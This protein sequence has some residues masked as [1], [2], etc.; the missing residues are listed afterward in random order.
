MYI[1]I[2]GICSGAMFLLQLGYW[3][4]LILHQIEV[5][6]DLIRHNHYT[7]HIAKRRLNRNSCLFI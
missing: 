1:T 6:I 7:G 5:I 3:V 2:I 4:V